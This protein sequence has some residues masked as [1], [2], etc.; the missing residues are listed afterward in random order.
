MHVVIF[1]TNWSETFFILRRI[2]RDMIKMYICVHAK[3]PLFLL[4]CN[5]T[6]IFSTDIRKNTQIS[7]FM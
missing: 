5:E 6:W 4:D 3:Y 2:E 7:N 1:S